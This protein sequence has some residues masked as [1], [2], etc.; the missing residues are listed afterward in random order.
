MLFHSFDFALF[1][2]LAFLLYWALASVSLKAQNAFIVLASYV[3]YG[4]RTS[5]KS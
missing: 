3:F 2:P 1:L 5:V 4:C